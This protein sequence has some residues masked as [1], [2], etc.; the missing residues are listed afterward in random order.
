MLI[1]AIPTWGK[2]VRPALRSCNPMVLMS[3]LSIMIEPP[4]ASITRNRA[5]EREDLPAPVLP[6]MPI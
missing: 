1:Y 2:I 5:M 6:T 3:R 4:A